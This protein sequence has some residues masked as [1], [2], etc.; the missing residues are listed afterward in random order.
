MMG[1]NRV[2]PGRRPDSG[3]ACAG[4]PGETISI[5]GKKSELQRK[6]PVE[7]AT[8]P[9]MVIMDLLGDQHVLDRRDGHAADAAMPGPHLL[10][11][12][13]A[14][15]QPNFLQFSFFKENLDLVL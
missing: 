9:S 7:G 10:L 13:S 6:G 12:P 3:K 5:L 1:S 4:L 2:L 8:G 15:E 14:S 11:P